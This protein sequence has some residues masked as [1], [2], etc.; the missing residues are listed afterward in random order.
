[1]STWLSAKYSKNFKLVTLYVFTLAC[2]ASSGAHAIVP[3]QAIGN[4]KGLVVD[5][6]ISNGVYLGVNASI[7]ELCNRPI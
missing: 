4:I 1:M 3:D 6:I 5:F 7:R 2:I